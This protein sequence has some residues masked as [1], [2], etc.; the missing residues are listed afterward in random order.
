MGVV[1]PKYI[2]LH[3]I[4]KIRFGAIPLIDVKM[5]LPATVSVRR[6]SQ[7][8]IMG[9]VNAAAGNGQTLVNAVLLLVNCKL[10]FELTLAE[11][12]GFP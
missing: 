7:C 11:V 1:V 3:S 12:N 9:S 4:L 5:P 2:A 6:S 10:P 8:G